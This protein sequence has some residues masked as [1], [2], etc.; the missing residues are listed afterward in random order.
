MAGTAEHAR[1]AL[2]LAG[3]NDH[4][5][6][7]G[8]AGFLGLAAWAAGDVTTALE[9]FTQA[10]ASLHAAGNLVDELSSTVML[11]DMWLAAGRPSRA[12]QL[13]RVHCS[14]PRRTASGGAMRPPNCTWGSARST[15]RSET[16]QSAR[17]HLEAAAA[18]ARPV[19]GMNER[20]YRWFVAMGLLANAEGDP[21]EA[22][23]LLDQ[24]EQLYRPGFFPDV[25][26]IAAMKARVWI[27]QGNLSE[28]ADWARDR[29]VS[30][31]DDASYL[32]EFDHLTLVRLLLA[33]Y[34]ANQDTD[35]LDQAGGLLDR[36][37]APP[38]PRDAPAVSSRS[39][40]CRRWHTTRRDVGRRPWSAWPGRWPRRPSR[41]ATCGSSWTRAPP[42][43]SCCAMPS[44]T[45][46]PAT[47]PGG[48]S[49]GNTPPA[50]PSRTGLPGLVG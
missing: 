20:R 8:A 3:P 22:I 46:S 47:T 13:Y 33:Q 7:G 35:A 17:R 34:R 36:L 19:A 29:G 23:D 48:C 45:A 31:A 9:T 49:A 5:A 38:R 6:R 2:D 28:A 37:A 50:A 44:S 24:A 25:R 11:A 27:A 39:A 1:R 15:S 14:W 10:V 4:L 21:E 16:S 40:C 32:R 12:R 41:T 30:V 26:P 18:L 42:W 43:P